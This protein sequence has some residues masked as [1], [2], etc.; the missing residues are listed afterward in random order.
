VT[1]VGSAKLTMLAVEEVLDEINAFKSELGAKMSRI[2]STVRNLDNVRENMQSAKGRIMDADF[3]EETAKLT[4]AM[5]LQQAG[6]S[7][8]SQA[9]TLPQSVLALLQG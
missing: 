1:T 4:Q 9:N 7:V 3:A 2:E 5:I 6:I 8:L